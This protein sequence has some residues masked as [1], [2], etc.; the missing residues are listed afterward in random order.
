[1]KKDLLVGLDVG[2]TKIFALVSKIKKEGGFDILGSGTV[3]SRGVTKGIVTDIKDTSQRIKKVIKEAEFD[4]GTRVERVWVSIA[5][6][7]IQG[8]NNQSFI[9]IENQDHLITSRDIEKVL[10]EA[11]SIVLP[12][13]QEIIHAL[14]QD[15]IV[16]GQDQIKDPVGMRGAQL[17]AKVYL[18]TAS[19]GARQNIEISIE[20]AGYQSEGVVLQSLAS[21]ISTLLP[22]EK[23]LGVALLDIGG[24]TTDVTIFFKEGMKFTSVLSIGGNHIT[25]DIAVGLHTTREKAEEIKIKYGAASL[26]YLDKDEFIQVEGVAGRGIY[27]VKRSRLVRI[28]QLRIEEM[29]ELVDRELKKSG[30]KDLVTS[31][32][33]LT[34]GSSLLPR[35][36]EKAEEKLGLPARIGYPRIEAL[37]Q[38]H[39]P[40]YATGI[41]LILYGLKRQEEICSREKLGIRIK[42][43]IKGFF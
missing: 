7:H 1:M 16:E 36:K 37:K 31:G 32:I 12:P 11:S 24:G 27:T 43:W 30:Y 14:P 42:E 33:V 18:V 2:T 26:D 8:K 40:L 39:S 17:Q 20:K 21:G 25:N 13:E 28:I 38:L 35:I 3:P 23:E 19:S 22:E 6:S 15:Y 10:K 4:S 34:G 41:G 5:G 9:K 29:F